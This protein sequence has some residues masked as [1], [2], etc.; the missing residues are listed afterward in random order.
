MVSCTVRHGESNSVLVL[1]QRGTGKTALLEC[2]LAQAD[3][4][5][6]GCRR[7]D[8]NGLTETNDRMALRKIARH[9]RMEEL[10]GDRVRAV[11]LALGVRSTGDG[12]G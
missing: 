5:R 1:G 10:V 8:L 6:E 7:V 9:L 3:L 11:E 12:L 2:V 4:E